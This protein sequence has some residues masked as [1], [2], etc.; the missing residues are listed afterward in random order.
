MKVQYIANDGKIFDD[1]YDCWAYESKKQVDK[2]IDKKELIFLSRSGEMIFG[3]ID[4]CAEEAAYIFINSEEALQALW[5][6][7]ECQRDVRPPA[8]GYWYYDCECDMWKSI[9]TKIEILKSKLSELNRIYDRFDY[10][11]RKPQ[12]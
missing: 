10:F 4:F 3:D 11:I 6:E 9:R 5:G 7:N 1:E 8:R 2:F 12:N